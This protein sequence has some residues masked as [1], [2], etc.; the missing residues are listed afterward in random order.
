MASKEP[1]RTAFPVVNELLVTEPAVT[2]APPITDP[3]TVVVPDT[4][5]APAIFPTASCEIPDTFRVSTVST[6]L[7]SIVP[8]TTTPPFKD[9]SDKTTNPFPV[10]LLSVNVSAISAVLLAS[11]EPLKV[12]LPVV[13]ELLRI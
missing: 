1:L 2:I 10:D 12:A 7:T 9:V 11:I 4:S 13:K 6:L 3:V 8:S 5:N